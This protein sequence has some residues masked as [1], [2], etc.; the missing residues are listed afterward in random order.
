MKSFVKLCAGVAGFSI[1][2]LMVVIAVGGLAMGVAAPGVM[3]LL[4]TMR[5]SEAARQVATDLQMARMKA[6]TR[7]TDYTVT[8]TSATKTYTWGTETR[9][10]ATLYPGITITASANPVFS[11]RGTATASTITLSNGSAQ[12]LVCVKTV[13][14]VNIASTCS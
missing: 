12:K 13:G 14:R 5:L 1:T 3:K 9:N 11:A 8:V 2:E 7:N 4:P 6:I 10:L